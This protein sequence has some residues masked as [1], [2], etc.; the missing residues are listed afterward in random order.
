MKKGLI[1]YIRVK[2]WDDLKDGKIKH[3]PCS[4][5]NIRRRGEHCKFG[6]GYDVLFYVICFRLSYLDGGLVRLS[7]GEYC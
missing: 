3:I 6:T 1:V 7:G 5:N 2:F 4:D